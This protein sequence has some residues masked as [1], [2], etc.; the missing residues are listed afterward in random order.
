MLFV[1]NTTKKSCTFIALI[2]IIAGENNNEDIYFAST[3]ESFEQS[4][5][6]KTAYYI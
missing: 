2:Y 4:S 3:N 5:S 6:F 1:H